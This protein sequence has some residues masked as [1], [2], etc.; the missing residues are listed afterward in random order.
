M[1]ETVIYNF[2]WLSFFLTSGV[3]CVRMDVNVSSSGICKGGLFRDV[4]EFKHAMKDCVVIVGS[5]EITFEQAKPEDFNNTQFN[6]LR[7]ITD[8]LVIYRVQGLESVG[9]LFPNLTRIRG[10]KLLYNFALIVYD[11]QDL[12]EIGLYNL[13]KIDRGG[14]ILWALPEA[15]FVE[16]IDWSAIA[17]K[18]RHVFS[19]PDNVIQ[20]NIPCSCS[21]ITSRNRCWN[22]RKCQLYIEG[23]DA[24]VCH[25]QCMGC[26]KTNKTKCFICRH[27]TH[28]YNCVSECPS[29][30]IVLPDNKYCITEEECHELERLVWNNTCVSECPMGYKKTGTTCKPCTHCEAN[31]SSLV[32]QS[33]GSIQNAERCVFVNGSLTIHL[34]AL[35]EAMG[36]LK[37]YLGHIEE[38]SHYVLIESSAVI[39]S[40]D[41]L[42]S[43]RVI[44]GERLKDDKYSLYVNLNYNLQ[45]LFSPN[46]TKN[47]IIKNGTALFEHNPVLCMNVIDEIKSRFPV[48][49][50]EIDIPLGSNGYRGG[51]KE[52]SFNFTIKALNETA[53][54]ISFPIENHDIYYSALYVRLPPGVQSTVVPESC[55]EFEWH[56]ADV[57]TTSDKNYTVVVLKSLLP[58]STY[59]LCIE[60]YDPKK[61]HLSRSNIVN[62]TTPVGK[63]E[64]PF[65]IELVALSSE[66]VVLK[67][68]DHKDYFQ[69]IE[70]YNLDVSLI[71]VN[72]TDFM[73]D[74]CEY[75]EEFF[76]DDDTRHALVRRPPPEYNRGCESM[77][78]ILAS[79]TPGAM[80][81]EYFDVCDDKHFGC[82]VHNESII[83]FNTT[84]GEYV[85]TLTLNISKTMEGLFMNESGNGFQV[86][87]LA[88]Y[89]DY[90]FRLRACVGNNCSRSARGAVRTLSSI[91]ADVPNITAAS[92]DALGNVVMNWEPPKVSN[93][94]IL[95]YYVEVLPRI[96]VNSLMP[97]VWCVAAHKTEIVVKSVITPKYL[98]RVCLRTLASSKSCGK[99]MEIAIP[100]PAEPSPTDPSQVKRTTKMDL[101]WSGVLTGILIYIASFVVGWFRNRTQI[102]S[103]IMPL[104]DST[105][106]QSMETD[107]PAAM[108][109]DAVPFHTI[110]LD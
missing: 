101:L 21:D 81:E 34:R 64:P 9:Q 74:Y 24:E 93:G 31:C 98:V 60:I 12:N 79:V 33:L 43:L 70:Y 67:W 57:P 84:Y 86:A 95:T 89:R 47:L 45:S 109:S 2:L 29:N 37:K 36:D 88:P 38:V 50:Q 27:Y 7:E 58:A 40:L 83:E 85:R 71:E 82:N 78:G 65:I 75:P 102:R 23:P 19:P 96:K 16:T 97:Q 59:A 52:V 41:F 15:C 91:D 54:E 6:N 72:S 56:D 73:I 8:Y 1:A 53:V 63:P 90:K 51:C 11:N 92:V 42:S 107:A 46:V 69:H 106:S 108:L 61:K 14:V 4:T 87:G 13:L 32:I 26:R 17:P 94:P 68:V 77:C 30:L 18:A 25:E 55:S 20:C 5:L 22:K 35:P 103:D 39:T 48:Q 28:Q 80:V 44:K 66:I 105:S 99:W 62:F 3:V 100:S 10:N 110:P 49:P 76:E 104:V